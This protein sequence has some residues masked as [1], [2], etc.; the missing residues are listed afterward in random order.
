[1]HS[2][3][4]SQDKNTHAHERTFSLF[5]ARAHTHK[6]CVSLAYPFSKALIP[7]LFPLH[8]FDTQPRC[9]PHSYT[10]NSLFL[11]SPS[12]SPSPYVVRCISYSSKQTMEAVVIMSPS[13]HARACVRL[14][15]WL[16][17]SVYL[18]LNMTSVDVPCHL[19]QGL[20]R[21]N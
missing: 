5:R 4:N 21:Q 13:G 20:A 15:S 3:A 1:M 18:P 11:Y 6:F 16:V 19:C 2:F 10:L 8:R 7:P 17:A 9:V 12:P 14:C